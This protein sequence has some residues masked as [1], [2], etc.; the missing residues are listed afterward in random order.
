[1]IRPVLEFAV[2]D[3]GPTYTLRNKPYFGP[4]FPAGSIFVLCWSL[5]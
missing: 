2:E 3:M 1:L 5:I 4:A